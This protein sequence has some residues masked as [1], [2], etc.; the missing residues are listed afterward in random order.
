MKE[1]KKIKLRTER[2]IVSML[3]ENTGVQ[4]MDSGGAS[5]RNLER[6]QGRTL[7]YFRSTPDTTIDPYVHSDA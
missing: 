4:M 3:T 1:W 7:A 2:M 5:G 6:N